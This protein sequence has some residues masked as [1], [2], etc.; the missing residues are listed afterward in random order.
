M[1][2]IVE[3][4]EA[5][6]VF[7]NL[8]TSACGSGCSYCYVPSGRSQPYDAR[9]VEAATTRFL[10][11]PQ[12]VPGRNGTMITFGG[13]TELFRGCD[14]MDSLIRTLSSVCRFGNPVQIST[15]QVVSGESIRAIRACA[16]YSG[17]ITLFVSCASISEAA[18]VE[19][20]ADPPAKR[21]ATFANLRAAGLR[22][23]LLIK[24][25]LGSS[26]ERDLPEFAKIAFEH[27]LDAVCLGALYVT[28]EISQRLS[29][30]DYRAHSDAVMATHP[31]ILERH[32]TFSPFPSIVSSFRTALHPIP[33][34]A[35]SF[36]V[37]AFFA[38]VACPI[39]GPQQCASLPNGN[40]SA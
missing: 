16:E 28:P 1:A 3:G 5:F 13:N 32:L 24:P 36:C 9:E 35:S 25:W 19:R 12:F 10:E 31:L 8:G 17:Q 4:T 2:M 22:A 18:A 14:L 29:S 7:V 20:A 33:L 23:A 15:K 37:T 26:T 6:R 11:S 40:R 27:D 39:H 34:F 21:W 30:F 38:R